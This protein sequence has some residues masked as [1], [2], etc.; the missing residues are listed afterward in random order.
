MT[1]RKEPK[2]QWL[3]GGRIHNFH[4]MEFAWANKK[5]QQCMR[6]TSCKDHL[7]DAVH[8]HYKGVNTTQ[9]YYPGTSPSLSFDRTRLIVA[10]TAKPDTFADEIPLMVDLLN[11][12]EKKLRLRKTKA[13]RISNPINEHKRCGAYLLESSAKWMI[14]PPMIS[15]YSLLVRSS[16]G[17][18]IGDTLEEAIVALR[19]GEGRL[20]AN[21]HRGISHTDRNYFVGGQKA[22]DRILK[23]RNKIWYKA[24]KDNYP[25]SW[26]YTNTHSLGVCGMSSG[27]S[28]TDQR[29][30]VPHWYRDIDKE[31]KEQE[32]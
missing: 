8:S 23:Y 30:V 17:H 2:I 11:L 22:I 7:Q 28:Y 24:R 18:N 4:Q 3:S 15:L 21:D 25:V 9:L 14:A 1:S 29:E 5:L 13:F 19:E 31:L 6:F 26:T 12:F 32:K 27:H 16:P 10:N 20:A